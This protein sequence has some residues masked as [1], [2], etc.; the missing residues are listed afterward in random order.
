MIPIQSHYD[1]VIIGAGHNGLVAASYL[2][3]ANLSVLMLECNA[4]VGGAT[5]SSRPFPG[6]DA[7]LSVYSYLVS[8]FPDKILKD[9]NLTFDLNSR[10]IASYT[11]NDIH[12]SLQELLISNE[13]EQVTRDSFSRLPGGQQDY[14]GYRS[15][16]SLQ[17]SLAQKL[18][19]SLLHPLVSRDQLKGT[20]SATEREAWDALIE[21]PLGDVIEKHLA[22]DLV[23]GMVFTDAKIGV[24]TFPHDPSLLQNITYLYHIIGRGTGE[25]RVPVGGMGALTA[26]LQSKALDQGATILTRARVIAIQADQK[27][28]TVH[29]ESEGKEHAID[30]RFI[31]NNAAPNLLDALLDRPANPPNLTDEGSV[32]KIN[33]LL[34]KL[35]SLR[36]ARTRSHDA[37]NGTFHLNEGYEEMTVNYHDS[38]AGALPKNA[39]GEMY[40][41]SLTD[42]S[43]LAAPLRDKGYQALTLFGLDMPYSLFQSANPPLRQAILDKY[44]AAINQF[45]AEPIEDCIAIDSNGNRCIEIKTP[46]D[47][48]TEI[49]LPRGNIFHN[50]LTWPFAEEKEEIGTWG[51]ETDTPNLFICGSGARRGG[52]VSGIPGHN[53]AMKIFEILQ[54]A[55]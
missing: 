13:S 3:G 27:R 1:V 22:N 10:R 42:P 20:L 33:L 16:M 32:V 5:K 55:P 54:I 24:S 46:V 9:L 47:L 7:N 6:M 25:W 23:R 2:A 38:R 19:P 11:P 4:T 18:W 45:T 40:C 17:Q 53:A 44:L 43:I 41:H 52:A 36:S 14:Q 21:N 48:E 37:F 31:L 35:P 29:Y 49:H 12:G 15:L 26:S 39:S 30:A 51:V 50:A 8:L 34:N 28:S